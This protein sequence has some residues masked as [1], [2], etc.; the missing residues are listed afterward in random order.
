[1]TWFPTYRTAAMGLRIARLFKNC[2]RKSF[3]FLCERNTPTFLHLLRPNCPESPS[4]I[5]PIIRLRVAFPWPARTDSPLMSNAA[6]FL[7]AESDTITR[8][9]FHGLTPGEYRYCVPFDVISVRWDGSG[10]FWS[11]RYNGC[12]APRPVQASVDQIMVV[13]QARC[14]IVCLFVF[15]FLQKASLGQGAFTGAWLMLVRTRSP[16]DQEHFGRFNLD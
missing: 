15:H 2:I 12:D 5:R 13:T 16:A 3:L 1:M 10:T 14:K 6:S 7:P 4:H 8:H 9:R 11:F